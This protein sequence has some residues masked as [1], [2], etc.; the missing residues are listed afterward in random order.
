MSCLA[1]PCEKTHRG[2]RYQR[3]PFVH[4]QYQYRRVANFRLVLPAVTCAVT[5][6]DHFDFAEILT[7]LFLSPSIL[8]QGMSSMC[9][10]TWWWPKPCNRWFLNSLNARTQ[11]SK[12]PDILFLCQFI[13][14]HRLHCEALLLPTIFGPIDINSSASSHSDVKCF[15]V[16]FL[17]FC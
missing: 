9:S 8:F 5:C 1:K 17:L 6:W 11:I 4:V 7:F 3:H 16:K 14:W 12:R 2:L 13:L 10:F 15:L